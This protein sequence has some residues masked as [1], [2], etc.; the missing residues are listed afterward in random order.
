MAN[1]TER[2]F[3]ALGD[4]GHQATTPFDGVP[5][6]RSLSKHDGDVVARMDDYQCLVHEITLSRK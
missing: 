6:G 5:C 2:D 3:V 4:V 1:R